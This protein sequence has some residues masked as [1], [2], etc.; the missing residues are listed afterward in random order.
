MRS[1][2]RE[3]DPLL[4]VVNLLTLETCVNRAMASTRFVILIDPL[5]AL[6]AE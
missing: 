2:V 4:P 5:A 1:I 3:L 6:R